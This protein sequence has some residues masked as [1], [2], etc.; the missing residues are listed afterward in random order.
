ME[1]QIKS[2]LMKL[3]EYGWEYLCALSKEDFDDYY[4]IDFEKADRSRVSF[5][6]FNGINLSFANMEAVERDYGDLA[7]VQLAPD[8]LI[9][10]LNICNR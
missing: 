1:E 5:V 10:F 9:L 3:K 8:E 6:I 4:E 7:Y 2:E